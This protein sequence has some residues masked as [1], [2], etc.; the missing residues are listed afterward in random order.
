LTPRI[1]IFEDNDILR[2]TLKYV[3][4]ERGY[5][6]FTFSD[7]GFC[8]LYDSINHKCPVDHACAD[9]ILSDVNLPTKTGLELIKEQQQKG[10]KVK[11]RALMS[12]DWTDSILKEARKLDCHIFHKPFNMENLFQW[13]NKCS[14]K[15]NSNRKLYDLIKEPD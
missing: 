1:L 11:Y 14:E 2:A 5:E 7:P 10:C 6:V 4:N 13:L 15:I 8:Q 9:I 3:L 12:G